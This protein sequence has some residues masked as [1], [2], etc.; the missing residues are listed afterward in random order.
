MRYRIPLIHNTTR[1]DKAYIGSYID[2]CLYLPF[3]SP[4]PT[5]YYTLYIH[6]LPHSLSLSFLHPFQ[7]SSRV[8]NAPHLY[9]RNINLVYTIIYIH[10]LYILLFSFFL[11]AQNHGNHN[12]LLTTHYS[13]DV[14][15]PKVDLER[16]VRLLETKSH[17]SGLHHHQPLPQTRHYPQLEHGQPLALP[18]QQHEQQQLQQQQLHYKQQQRQ[19]QQHL[20]DLARQ[21]QRG[22][23]RDDLPE[24]PNIIDVL[25]REAAD[26]LEYV[27]ELER[28]RLLPYVEY[29]PQHRV[30]PYSVEDEAR[31][32][33]LYTVCADE[34]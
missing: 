33:L 21:K 16:L 25:Q 10:F 24:R 15:P 17:A 22:L 29:E 7:K 26:P 13:T 19:H 6:K 4:Y 27:R 23:L 11:F 34:D 3:I 1:P 30:K 2:E 14:E 18:L 28:Q 8:I 12:Q 32:S 31:V 9:R 20:L 5:F